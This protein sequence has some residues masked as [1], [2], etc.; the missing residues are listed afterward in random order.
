MGVA[1][2]ARPI[3]S[4]PAA[5]GGR[6]WASHLG[7]DKRL[8]SCSSSHGRPSRS[9]GGTSRWPGVA[10]TCTSRARAWA[11]RLPSAWVTRLG[12][13]S[14]S[15]SSST[16][17]ATGCGVGSASVGRRSRRATRMSCGAASSA[18]Q[19]RATWIGCSSKSASSAPSGVPSS[20]SGTTGKAS[21]PPRSFCKASAC[22]NSLPTQADPWAHGETSTRTPAERPMARRIVASSGS[23][24]WNSRESMVMGVPSSASAVRSLRTESSSPLLCDRKWVLLSG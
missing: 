8:P 4:R 7:R 23:P 20:N 15:T 9:G 14:S 6:G 1:T 16:G 21:A 5:F 17:S 12:S 13:H 10:G 22:F 3:A 24:P 2:T 18:V 11:R 19:R